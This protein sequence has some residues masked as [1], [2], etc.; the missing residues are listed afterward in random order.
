EAIPVEVRYTSYEEAVKSGVVALF[1]EKY[2]DVVRV[3][4]VPGVSKELCGGT[5]VKNTGQIG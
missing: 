2:G 3:V 4:E 1:T 5:H